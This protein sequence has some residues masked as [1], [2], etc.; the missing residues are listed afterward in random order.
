M[1]N[2]PDKLQKLID[3]ARKAEPTKDAAATG[4]HSLDLTSLND[5]DT[6][7]KIDALVKKADQ[8]PLG[9]VA[10]TCVYPKFLT[11]VFNAT[12]KKGIGNATVLNFPSGVGEPEQTYIDTKKA[13]L[14]GATEVD[15]V[16]D[17]N[18]FL[19]GDLG[20]ALETLDAC[21]AASAGFAKMKVILES[22]AFDDYRDLYSAS[23][24]AIGAGADFIKTS[25]G[26]SAAGGAT[27]EAAATMMQAINDSGTADHVGLKVS[28]GV[29]TVTDV[30]QYVALTKEMMGDNWISTNTFRIGASGVLT[31]ILKTLG[32]APAAP[33]APAPGAPTY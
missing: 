24:L 1:K 7:E 13:I 30:A 23:M 26:K 32:A 18:A 16:L 6:P 10:A 14:A 21:R 25:T 33:A 8:G 15:I 3:E 17:Y 22:A 5:D 4:L 2:L 19:K 29:K 20:K 9:H 27:L 11:Q 12:A 31:D 28:G